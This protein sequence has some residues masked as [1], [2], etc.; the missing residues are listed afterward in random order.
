MA[1]LSRNEQM[2]N[3]LP[4]FWF[5]SI[6][7]AYIVLN[8]YAN[9][10]PTEMALRRNHMNK[11]LED[12]R[13]FGDVKGSGGRFFIGPGYSFMKFP[14]KVQH[15]TMLKKGG[16]STEVK[17]QTGD[18]LT[19]DIEIAVQ[20]QFHT[21]AAALK[22]MFMDF[23]GAEEASAYMVKYLRAEFRF[24][25][26]QYS[27]F[28]LWVKRGEVGM[29]L[30]EAATNVLNKHHATCIGLQLLSINIDVDIESAIQDTAVAFQRVQTARN[31]LEASRVRERTRVLETIAN[32]E[33]MIQRANASAI[34]IEYDAEVYVESLDL[35]AQSQVNAYKSVKRN[36]GFSNDE[37]LK[38]IWLQTIDKNNLA[39]GNRVALDVPASVL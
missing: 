30:K 14:K 21:D 31:E 38:F 29:K 19:F 10:G 39:G 5:T 8:A 4:V 1:D 34:E 13:V 26:I 17:C 24:I 28:E 32:T 36:L 6:V 18:G 9:I 20:Y 33:I 35:V 23:G 27:V 22:K 3:S 12:G 11:E 16:M 7:L 15:I 2:K 25:T 37:L